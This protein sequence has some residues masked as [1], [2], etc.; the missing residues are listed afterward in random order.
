M[1]KNEIIIIFAIIGTFVVIATSLPLIE[2]SVAANYLEIQELSFENEVHI[3][4]PVTVEMEWNSSAISYDLLDDR[5]YIYWIVP[6]EQYRDIDFHIETTN[7]PERL[8]LLEDEFIKFQQGKPSEKIIEKDRDSRGT[9]SF[10]SNTSGKYV[11][12]CILGSDFE[13]G[14]EFSVNVSWLFS[15]LE[16]EITGYRTEIEYMI[17]IETRTISKK[18]SI[19][20]KLFGI[21]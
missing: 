14:D 21:Y 20:Q 15:T 6:I 2:V 8:V 9:L 16:K 12:V 13:K 3:N 17:K 19:S 10:I 7:N 11:F 5:F 1:K 18:V 4:Y